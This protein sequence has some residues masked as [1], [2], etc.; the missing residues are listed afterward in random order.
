[1]SL[2]RIQKEELLKYEHVLETSR[3]GYA[4]ISTSDFAKMLEIY[5]GP[6][7]K[8]KTPRTVLTCGTCKLNELQKI[9]R[10]YYA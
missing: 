6:D 5:Y 2:S 7:W 4:R 10:E 9:A 3:C 1:M 8:S